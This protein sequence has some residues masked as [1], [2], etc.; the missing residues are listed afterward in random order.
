MKDRGEHESRLVAEQK[1]TEREERRTLAAEHVRSEPGGLLALLS[2]ESQRAANE[3]RDAEAVG[4]FKRREHPY[5]SSLTSE[6]RPYRERTGEIGH[7]RPRLPV[8][9]GGHWLLELERRRLLRTITQ[10]SNDRLV[11]GLESSHKRVELS[12]GPHA[13][14]GETSD[15]IA[16]SETRTL[17]DAIWSNLPDVHAF[18]AGR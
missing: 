16:R 7:R 15:H 13:L 5:N 12:H 4:G 3:P 8:I 17:G 9:A 1:P 14:T 2:L 18:G 6:A 10:K 11:A